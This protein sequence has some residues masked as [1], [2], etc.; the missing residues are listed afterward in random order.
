MSSVAGYVSSERRAPRLR[1]LV[2]LGIALSQLPALSI[3]A[4]APSGPSALATAPS[5]S[6][7]AS[8]A[9]ALGHAEE[10]VRRRALSDLMSLGDD[11]LPALQQHLESL[12]SHGFDPAAT[13]TAMS[14]LRRVQGAATPEQE[15]DLAQGILPMLAKQRDRH[16]LLAA[17]LIAILRALEAQKSTEAA[18]LIVGKLFALDGKLFRYEAPRTRARLGV[19]L[20][21]ALIRYQT[22]PRT[23]IR[24][25]CQ[26]SLV[27]LRV[28]KPG[29]AVQ[30]DDVALLAAILSAYGTTLNFEAMPIVVSYV[31][32][33]RNEVR[34]AAR[35]AVTRYGK[36]A[37]WQLRERYLNATGKEA[38]PSWGHQRL[39]SELAKLFDGP[40]RTSVE[41]ALLEASRHLDKGFLAPASEALERALFTSPSGE[42]AARAAPLYARLA[43][44]Y[45]AA[46]EP[47]HAL[48]AYRRALRL[49]PGAGNASSLRGRISY[50]EA[51][52]RLARGQVDLTGYERAAALDPSLLAARDTLEELTGERARRERTRRQTLGFAAAG[53]LAIAAFLVLRNRRTVEAPAAVSEPQEPPAAA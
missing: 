30:Q 36:N 10:P 48:A 39:L 5:S 19:L 51:D 29:R 26:D 43:A 52:Q 17:Q 13:L 3:D 23:W 12:S 42:L 32:D 20:I 38:E 18:E 50:L 37:I 41:V 27:Q 33:E 22:H 45:E 15:V 8:L 2:I 28:D 46:E 34:D 6:E 53:L 1:W 40:K 14:E 7:L 49:A 16:A 11:A 21:P 24:N 47:S 31:T 9:S 35:A 25:F 44:H 4:Q